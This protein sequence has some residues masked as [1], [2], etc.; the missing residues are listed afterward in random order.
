MQL[1]E[2]QWR[3]QSHNTDSKKSHISILSIKDHVEN[4]DLDG[5]LI[6][7]FCQSISKSRVKS[8]QSLLVEWAIVSPLFIVISPV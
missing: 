6:S 7:M 2:E 3:K 5:H 1:I 8:F 4:I